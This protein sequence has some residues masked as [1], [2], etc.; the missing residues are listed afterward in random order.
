MVKVLCNG[1]LGY[2]LILLSIM[3]SNSATAAKDPFSEKREL[4][5]SRLMAA[6]EWLIANGLNFYQLNGEKD[7]NQ[8]LGKELL[9]SPYRPS[10]VDQDD[11]YT[12]F[13]ITLGGSFFNV[14]CF[15]RM[16]ESG[17]LYELWTIQTAFAP[18]SGIDDKT[19]FYYAKASSF[20]AVRSVELKTNDLKPVFTFMDGYTFE[21]PLDD[22]MV[23]AKIL[24]IQR[25]QEQKNRENDNELKRI[26]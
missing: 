1:M 2:I 20:Y 14:S 19:I 13:G 12:V 24:K 15:Y 25:R 5:T 4:W 7:F 16:L 23:K 3:N 6:S 22:E 17:K 21:I 9:V 26:F 18:E 8:K 10:Y 11:A